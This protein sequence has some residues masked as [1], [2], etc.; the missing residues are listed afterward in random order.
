MVW[1]VG[2]GLIASDLCSCCF[3]LSILSQ[4]VSIN[5][6]RSIVSGVRLVK[7]CKPWPRG[8]CCIVLAVMVASLSRPVMARSSIKRSAIALLSSRL[9][10]GGL[11]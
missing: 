3:I 1:D 8:P 5:V 11:Q 6:V 7:L 2:S 4:A 9:E 10:V